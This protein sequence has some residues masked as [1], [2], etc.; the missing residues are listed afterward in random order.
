MRKSSTI[1]MDKD[2]KVKINKVRYENSLEI[3]DLSK[4]KESEVADLGQTGGTNLII[5]KNVERFNS[6]GTYRKGYISAAFAN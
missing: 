1:K 2:K 3:E 6:S 4:S 5:S